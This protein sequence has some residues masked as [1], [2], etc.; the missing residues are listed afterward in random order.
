LNSILLYTKSYSA[1]Q[2]YVFDF[3]FREIYGVNFEVL[4]SASAFAQGEGFKINYSEEGLPADLQ[5]MPHG[6]LFELDIAAQT[7]SVVQWQGL[8]VFF[9]TSV[10]QVP[11]DLFSAVFYLLSRYEE[12][13]PYTPDEF[14]R[15]PHTASVA[16][17][18]HF[19]HL[20]LADLWLK[21]L[22]ELMLKSEP[23]LQ[24]RRNKFH[25]TPTY[26]I[27]IAYSYSGKGM[28]RNLAGAVQDIGRADLK[29]IKNRSAVLRGALQDPYD[30]YAFLDDLH[31][32][33]KLQ[34]VYF[35]LAGNNGK[36]DK[37]LPFESV[38][39][40]HLFA[41]ISSRYEVGIHPSFQSH[42]NKTILKDEIAKI[43]TGKSRQHY[44]RFQLPQTFRN[45]LELGIKEEYSMGYGS[46]NGF[47]A[48]TSF[49]FLWF[50]L[51]KNETTDL[52]LFPFC[53]MECNS[54]FEQHY[55]AA[56]AAEEL[57]R[58][59]ETVRQV[60]GHLI[61]IWHNFSLGT[62]PLWEG[63]RLVY[64]EFLAKL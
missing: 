64:E 63:W 36:L 29:S 51:E 43:P 46:I 45:L 35:F 12:Y 49:S 59:L 3:I 20:P 56:Q 40:Q 38:V 52:R 15:F 1:R 24:F 44:I 2:A 16:F 47:R 7:I 4:T 42:D 26:D 19:L 30:S 34:P 25:F 55:S 48:G 62:D 9:Q 17:K 21:E 50:D 28:V 13:L 23:D 39:M 37:N 27:D 60:D 22:K 5:I 33:Y 18:Q 53:F 32:R 57:N 41:R 58:Y 10:S 61:S 11:F 54:F 14:Q 8:P 31:A 6:L